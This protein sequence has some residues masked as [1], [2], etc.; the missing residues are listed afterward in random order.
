MKK[1]KS[2]LTIKNIFAPVDYLGKTEYISVPFLNFNCNEKTALYINNQN[3][4]LTFDALWNAINNDSSVTLAYTKKDEEDHDIETKVIIDKNEIL[5]KIAVFDI[6]EVTDEVDKEI[7]LFD[8]WNN[9]ISIPDSDK[10]LSEVNLLFKDFEIATKNTLYNIISKYSQKIIDI[11]QNNIKEARIL[12]K[13]LASP[14]ILTDKLEFHNNLVLLDEIGE[15]YQNDIFAVFMDFFQS[16]KD[17]HEQLLKN[18]EFSNTILQKQTIKDGQLKLYYMNKINNSSINKVDNDFKIKKLKIEKDFYLDFQKNTKVKASHLLSFIMNS[19]KNEIHILNFKLKNLNPTSPEYFET[20][21]DVLI[22]RKVYK[23]LMCNRYDL[24]YLSASKIWELNEHLNSEIK[25]FVNESFRFRKIDQS[26]QVLKKIRKLV[27]YEFSFKIDSYLNESK[28]SKIEIEQKIQF[29]EK[30]IKKLSKLNFQKVA[31]SKNSLKMRRFEQQIKMA[32]AELE[33]SK[34]SEKKLFNSLLKSKEIKIRRLNNSLKN[35]YNEISKLKTQISDLAKTH[36]NIF[37]EEETFE[38]LREHFNFLSE[39]R[40]MTD[41]T[42]I[43]ANFTISKISAS[44]KIL[45]IYKNILK[46]IDTVESISIQKNSYLIPYKK[47][48][49]VDKAKIKLMKHVLSETDLLFVKDNN[50]NIPLEIRLEFLRVLFKISKK[51]NFNFV[52]VTHH[53]GLIKGNFEKVHFFNNYSLVEGGQ[54]CRVLG[55]PKH[56]SVI[57]LIRS[58]K[59][60]IPDSRETN[61]FIYDDIFEIDSNHYVYAS[62]NQFQ[63]WNDYSNQIQNNEFSHADYISKTSTNIIDDFESIFNDYE[64]ELEFDISKDNLNKKEKELL[65]ELKNNTEE[66]EN[67]AVDENINETF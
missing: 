46:F 44:P 28:E 27:K 63:K 9:T 65:E 17:N 15:N 49:I 6:L 50:K 31:N 35:L 25:I 12:S 64:F 30:E 62:L 38:S 52:F 56:P 47:L 20:Y 40:W 2:L 18:Y 67:D 10:L 14:E 39:S 29:F 59:Y 60:L 3:N 43:L 66:I 36:S 55:E 42:S 57:S 21:K 22:K 13:K 41:V 5:K 58:K 8:I 45:T 23:L 32:Q 24:L 54:V 48:K 34:F 16:L 7:P 51:Y 53:L 4:I 37:Y 26:L 33:W 19:V 1:N 11:N 61:L